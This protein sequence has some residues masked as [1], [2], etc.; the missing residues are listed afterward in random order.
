MCRT[1]TGPSR[2]A[3]Q[4]RWSPCVSCQSS[5]SP[6]MT[7]TSHPDAP[8][9]DAA[10]LRLAQAPACAN[11]SSAASYSGASGC[12]VGVIPGLA[13]LWQETQGDQRICIAVLDGPVDVRHISFRH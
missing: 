11:R 5:A 8:E 3:I 6:G 2:T 10:E 9:Y 4:I 1:S 13:E 12:D 7:P